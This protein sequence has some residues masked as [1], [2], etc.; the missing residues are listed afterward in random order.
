MITLKKVSVKGDRAMT[1]LAIETT[2]Q[3]DIILS[4]IGPNTKGE[5]VEA[6]IE[7]CTMA[8]GGRAPNVFRALH[9]LIVAVAQD[10]ESG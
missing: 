10:A 4:V 6:Q 2:H 7:F 3:G 1:S 8:G 5:M 9:D